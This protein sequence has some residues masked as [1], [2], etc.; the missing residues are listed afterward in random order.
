[1]STTGGSFPLVRLAE[2]ESG[3]HHIREQTD[4]DRRAHAER[5]RSFEEK[6]TD[7]DLATR[8]N[9]VA[10]A[11]IA[12]SVSSLKWVLGTVVPAALGAAWVLGRLIH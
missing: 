8:A 10:L 11:S 12:G 7:I 1:M 4:M 2:L 5:H 3:Q 6:I 9:T